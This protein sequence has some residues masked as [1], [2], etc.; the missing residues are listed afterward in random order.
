MSSYKYWGESPDL[1]EKPFPGV[2][3]VTDSRVHCEDGEAWSELMPEYAIPV[4]IATDYS[5]AMAVI[6]GDR[7]EEVLDEWASRRSYRMK[8]WACDADAVWREYTEARR[9]ADIDEARKAAREEG[10]E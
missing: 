4:A 10:D 8:S 6:S 1:A 3:Y 7:R 2:G 5:V 9:L